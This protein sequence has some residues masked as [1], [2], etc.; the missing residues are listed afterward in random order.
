MKKTLIC[1]K[2]AGRRLLHVEQ[3]KVPVHDGKITNGGP[4]PLSV[5]ISHG[6]FTGFRPV[7]AFETFICQGCGYAEWYAHGAAAIAID[8]KLGIRLIDNEPAGGLR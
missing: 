3:M 5:G 8:E 7:G 1:P 2:C 4:F 6:A